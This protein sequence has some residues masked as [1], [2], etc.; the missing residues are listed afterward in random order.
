[1]SVG[2]KTCLTTPQKLLVQFHPNF[3]EKISTKASLV[4]HT[5]GILW[6]NDF[7]HGP[8]IILF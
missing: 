3:T 4:V 2:H 8:L 5:V 1:V 6:F 7:F